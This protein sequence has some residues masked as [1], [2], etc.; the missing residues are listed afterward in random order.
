MLAVHCTESSE[1]SEGERNPFL[2]YSFVCGF[3]YYYL[4]IAVGRHAYQVQST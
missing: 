3:Y 1:S 2:Y 4:F